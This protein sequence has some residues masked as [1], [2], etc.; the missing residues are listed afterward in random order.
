MDA[1]AI[2]MAFFYFE[3]SMFYIDSYIWLSYWFKVAS[4]NPSIMYYFILESK[5]PAENPMFIAVSILSPV[6]TQT[7]IPVCFMN[8]IESET[9]S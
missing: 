7:L 4:S 2:T 5:S 9:S 6:S 8:L 1:P 3:L